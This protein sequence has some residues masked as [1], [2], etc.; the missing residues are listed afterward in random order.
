MKSSVVKAL[1]MGKYWPVLV[2]TCTRR[3]C[4]ECFVLSQFPGL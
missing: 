1:V 4:Q 3:G 2:G